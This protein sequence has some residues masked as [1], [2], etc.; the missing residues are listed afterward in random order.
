MVM[1]RTMGMPPTVATVLKK[2]EPA[3]RQEFEPICKARDIVYPPK[4]IQLLAFKQEKQLELWGANSDTDFQHLATFPIVGMSGGPGPKRKSG[5]HQVPEGF[6]RLTTLNPQS[7]FHLSIR[8][9]YPNTEDIQHATVA[10][11]YMGGDIYVHGREA[12]VG[13]LAMGDPAIEKI[14]CL[15][16]Q[17]DPEQR[18]I[19]IAPRDYRLEPPER[20]Q[21]ADEWLRDL[22][23]RLSD[24]L[25]RFPSQPET[26]A[27]VQ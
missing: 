20:T 24:A 13:C 22:Y 7:G 21:L 10:R 18:N 1:N 16:A 23:S 12:S 8:V 15:V 3:V 14:F 5:D 26:V 2:Y 19:L 27:T 4:G 17:S 11:Q 25:A 9:D 6:Y